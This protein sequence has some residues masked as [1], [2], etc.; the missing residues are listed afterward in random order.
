MHVYM[1]VLLK[2]IYTYSSNSH[3]L[4]FPKYVLLVFVF[5]FQLSLNSFISLIVFCFNYLLV[6]LRGMPHVGLPGPVHCKLVIQS[7]STSY[8]T[9][10]KVF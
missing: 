2:N 9:F 10:P 8:G 7:F 3:E 5:F 4:L 6:G 1:Y